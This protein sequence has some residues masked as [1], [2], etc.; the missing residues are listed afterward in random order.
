MGRSASALTRFAAFRGLILVAGAA[1]LSACASAPQPGPS[2]AAPSGGGSAQPAP[3]AAPVNPNAPV[4]LALI[5]P[6]TSSS[7][8]AARAA[9]D[10]VAAA[11]IAMAERAPAN[12]V[13]KIYDSKGTAAGAAEAASHAVRDGAAL[14]LGPLLGD[15]TAAAAPVAAQGGL[16]ILSFSNDA[17]VAGGNVWLLGWLPGDE[18]RRVLGYAGSQGIGRV[19][20]VRPADRYGDAVSAEAPRAARDAGVSLSPELTYERSFQGIES[21][22][23]SGAGAILASGAG[24]VLIADA[25]DALR[26]M[27]SFLAYYDVSPRT[28]RYLGLSRWD[29]ARNAAE[30]TLQ[31]GWFAAPDPSSR[32][33]FAA[34]FESR[35]ARP[36]SPLASLGYDGVAAAADML[37][38]AQAGGPVAFS[39]ASIVAAPHEGAT[40]AFR[41]TP[42][43][44]NR[45]AL[46]V[47]EMTPNG[48]A[49]LDPAPSAAPGV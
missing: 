34:A 10:L 47:M 9:Q 5:A 32:A 44:L 23:Q 4:T 8:A 6:T 45:R 49:L 29:D 40:G 36:P 22:S 35:M 11:Q 46:A 17:S 21:A 12:L 30:S 39:P 7:Q 26:A 14:I 25:G 37:R 18:M 48:P 20:L 42:D 3:V 16:S 19:A 2:A 38:A 1:L 41:L 24:G 33:A 43:G 28:V 27:S 31:G 15:G 13:M